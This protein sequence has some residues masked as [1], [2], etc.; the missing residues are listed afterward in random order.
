MTI[1]EIHITDLKSIVNEIE[2]S[3]WDCNALLSVI[4]GEIEM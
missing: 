1:T 3:N 2:R 4:K